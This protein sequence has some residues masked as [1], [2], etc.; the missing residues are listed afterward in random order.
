[1]IL[2]TAKEYCFLDTNLFATKKLYQQKMFRSSWIPEIQL[3]KVGLGT[4]GG[5]LSI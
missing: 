1:L 3:K 2:Q 4:L 5:R